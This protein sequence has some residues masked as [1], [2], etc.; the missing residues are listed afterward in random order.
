MF[1]FCCFWLQEVNRPVKR[2]NKMRWRVAEGESVVPNV[3]AAVCA[4]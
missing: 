4:R 3:G 1:L 2:K